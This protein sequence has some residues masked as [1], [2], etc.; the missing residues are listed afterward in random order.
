MHK[1]VLII[2]AGPNGSGKTSITSKIIKHDWMEDSIYINPDNIAQE[3]FGDWNS[4]EAVMKA[5]KAKVLL[6]LNL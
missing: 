1:P 3:K 4:S 2:I 6:H 5:A